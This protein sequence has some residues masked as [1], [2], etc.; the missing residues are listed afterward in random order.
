M[1]LIDKIK[2]SMTIK[3]TDTNGEEYPL[4]VEVDNFNYKDITITDTDHKD[5]LSITM[6]LKDAITL[7]AFIVQLNSEV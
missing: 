3:L 1:K 5:K 6:T 2:E 4:L 7:S